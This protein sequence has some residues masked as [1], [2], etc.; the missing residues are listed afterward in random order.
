[1]AETLKLPSGTRF[2]R[3]ADRSNTQWQRH[4]AV[5]EGNRMSLRGT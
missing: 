5:E 1:M 4:L 3:S 2:S